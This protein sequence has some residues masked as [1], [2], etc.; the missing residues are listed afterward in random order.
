MPPRVRT[1][2]RATPRRRISAAL[3][4]INGCTVISPAEATEPVRF[5][6]SDGGRGRPPGRGVPSRPARTPVHVHPHTDEALYVAD[7][8]VTFLL[9]DRE[10]LLTG[11]GLVF[12]PR[13]MPHAVW[14]SGDGPARGPL[15]ISRTTPSACSS[16]SRPTRPTGIAPRLLRIAMIESAPDR[17]A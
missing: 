9:G 15:V 12:V 16:P 17:P 8:D 13:G 10:L 6:P 11:G 4:T 1:R 2:A 5:G 3:E 7:E 14:N